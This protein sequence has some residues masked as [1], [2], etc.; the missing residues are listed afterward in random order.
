MPDNFV[1]TEESVRIL[2]RV[3]DD[4]RRTPRNKPGHTPEPELPQAPDVYVALTP[5]TGIPAMRGDW[6]TGTG[7]LPAGT[8]S[9][10]QG[11]T[12]GSADCNIYR[13]VYTGTTP[14]VPNLTAMGFTRKILNLSFTAVPANSWVIVQR[15]KYGDWYTKDER[16]SATGTGGG[17]TVLVRNKAYPS[18]TYTSFTGTSDIDFDNATG[19]QVIT[20]GTGVVI[21]KG[22]MCAYDATNP[23]AG[24]LND[25][26]STQV[27]PG[28][29][30]IRTGAA[31]PVLNVRLDY[32]PGQVT[33]Y[34]ALAIQDNASTMMTMEAHRNSASNL[35]DLVYRQIYLTRD[36]NNA[37]A[38][39]V[40]STYTNSTTYTENFSFL[41][42]ITSTG[43][44]VNGPNLAFTLTNTAGVYTSTY[45]F[46]NNTNT[47]QFVFGTVSGN[48][49]TLQTKVA[50]NTM[51]ESSNLM[52][53]NYVAGWA[54]RLAVSSAPANTGSTGTTGA[55]VLSSGF[56][57]ICVATDDWRRVALSSF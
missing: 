29:K 17:T 7:L 18:G 2:Q 43:S 10:H 48:A 15:D 47:L 24:M 35:N 4:V 46:N 19:L 3:L 45:S 1:L 40:T 53:V 39:L 11:N 42:G 32:T 6:D 51:A 8:A 52:G 50:G 30:T 38:V 21:A 23:Q 9:G 13:T 36:G 25:G 49:D 34:Y 55:M 54:R 14:D 27:I 22:V 16:G 12:P 41:P 20:N 37:G 31:G 5:G 57:Y 28:L 26:N 56:L 44:V 33:T